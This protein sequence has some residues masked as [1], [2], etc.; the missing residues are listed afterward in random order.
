MTVLTAMLVAVVGYRLD[1]LGVAL[2]LL[3]AVTFG[4]QLVLFCRRNNVFLSHSGGLLPVEESVEQSAVMTVS[5]APAR[6][7]VRP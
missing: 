7:R 5:L 1:P 6:G 2:L 4:L 3:A